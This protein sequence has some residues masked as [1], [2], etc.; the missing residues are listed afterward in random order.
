MFIMSV[1]LSF[2]LSVRLIKCGPGVGRQGAPR[3]G[4][5]GLAA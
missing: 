5:G 3:G 4:Y 2:C 1:C